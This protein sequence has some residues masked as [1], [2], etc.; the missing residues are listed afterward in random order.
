MPNTIYDI[1]KHNYTHNI[2]EKGVATLLHPLRNQGDP[3]P[4]AFALQYHQTDVVIAYP[5][6][7]VVL[8]SGGFSTP[9]Y[10]WSNRTMT[11]SP[12]TRERISRY[13]PKGYSLS[14]QNNKWWLSMPNGATVEFKDGM[15][16]GANSGALQPY[17]VADEQFSYN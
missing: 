3:E 16:I 7:S 9:H 15:I 6:G 14:Q 4:Y 12:T 8:N 2:R 5:D 1:M 11:V 17:S 10:A 13:L